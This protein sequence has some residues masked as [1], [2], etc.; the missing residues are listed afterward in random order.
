MDAGRLTLSRDE[1]REMGYRVV[2]L[3]VE[4][5]AGLLENDTIVEGG[6]REEM[7]ALFREPLPRQ[8]HPPMEVLERTARDVLRHV[9]HVD[10]P[11]FLAFIPGPSNFVGAM[12]AAL[13]AGINVFAGNWYEGAAAAQVELLVLDWLRELFGLPREAGG[14]FVSG[15]S[16]ANVTAL[17]VARRVMLED[18]VEGA[19]VYV[20]DQ[21]HSSVERGLRLLGFPPEAIRRLPTDSDFRLDPGVVAAAVEADRRAG[22][23]PFCVVATAGTTNTGAVDPLPPLRTLCTEEELWLHVDGAYGAGAILCP[24]G[25]EQLQGIGGV[26]SFS[27][28]PHKWL[29]QPFE[30][31]VVWVRSDRELVETFRILPEYLKDVD[32]RAGEVNYCDRGIQLTRSF[33]ALPLWMSLQ[34]FGR[35][36][37]EE[38]VGRGF[39]MAR[40]LAGALELR[41]WEIVTRPSMGIVTFRYAPAGWSG[42][43]VDRLTRGLVEAIDARR[44]TVIFSTELRGRPVLRACPINPRL[45][46]EEMEAVAEHLHGL[47]VELVGRG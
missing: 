6:T 19:V 29:F 32:A 45:T 16:A 14:L 28:D 21:T 10:H 3:L 4:H 33:R 2:D 26:D 47:A 1:M 42:E 7:E 41:G 39:E 23:R 40:V 5:H 22:L 9:N 25:R 36:G 44:F 18:R 38:G 37:F 12:G 30:S 20:G 8:G 17:A 46:P 27:L 11:R 31:G 43:A 24:E 13:A 35:E 15:G 34:V